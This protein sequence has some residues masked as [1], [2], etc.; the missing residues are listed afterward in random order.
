MA[1]RVAKVVK[2]FRAGYPSYMPS[3]GYVPLV[4]LL[5]RRL[6]DDEVITITNE[7]AM[8]RHRPVSTADIGVAITRITN[9]LPSLDDIERVH[10]RLD[11]TGRRCA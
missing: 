6:S 11:A 10:R 1:D 2:F 7:L 3:T 5:P 8:P 9:E 4:A